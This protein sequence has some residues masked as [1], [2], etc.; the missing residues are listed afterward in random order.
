MIY[1]TTKV[2]K[3]LMY[4]T[5]IQNLSVDG[6][7]VMMMMMMVNH[8]KVRGRSNCCH[9]LHTLVRLL[10]ACNINVHHHYPLW[11]TWINEMLILEAEFR[12]SV[13]NKTWLSY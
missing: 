5:I 6:V 4:K 11:I 1:K 8:V 13:K 7:K 10:L 12:I 9:F 3:I 2:E